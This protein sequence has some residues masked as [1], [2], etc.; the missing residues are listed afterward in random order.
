MF[1]QRGHS[2]ICANVRDGFPHVTRTCRS[3]CR[4]RR[5]IDQADTEIETKDSYQRGKSVIGARPRSSCFSRVITYV[6]MNFTRRTL[7]RSLAIY[8][9]FARTMTQRQFQLRKHTASHTYV[10]YARVCGEQ[11]LPS[12]VDSCRNY[13]YQVRRILS[14]GSKDVNS[15]LN[16]ELLGQRSQCD[17]VFI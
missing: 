17:S 5:A 9:A 4:E 7:P 16:F 1:R 15:D 8:A 3:W 13:W 10:W 14:V 12:S 2:H 6:T 11:Q